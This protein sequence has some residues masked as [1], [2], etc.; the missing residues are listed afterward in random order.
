MFATRCN[1][2][3]G[4]GWHLQL[5]H[6]F[7][8]RDLVLVDLVDLVDLVLSDHCQY[9]S[10]RWRIEARSYNMAGNGALY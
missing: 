5:L 10:S 6:G 8:S 2:K 3:G 9:F 7:T 1:R 4:F